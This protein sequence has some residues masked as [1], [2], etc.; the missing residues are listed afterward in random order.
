[1]ERKYNNINIQENGQEKSGQI[2][3]NIP[4]KRY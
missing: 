2:Q 1:M 3:R 4:I